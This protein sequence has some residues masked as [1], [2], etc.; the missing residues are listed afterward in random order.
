MRDSLCGVRGAGCGVRGA[1]C[2]VHVLGPGTSR[3]DRI[4]KVRE[5]AAIPSVRRYVILEAPSAGLTVLERGGA[6]EAWRAATLLADDVLH[7]PKIAVSVPVA[8]LYE[9]IPFQ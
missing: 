8:E 5:Y 3:A 7:M 2:W 9:G 6:D 1:V 4:D